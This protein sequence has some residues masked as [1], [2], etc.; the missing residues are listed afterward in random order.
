MKFRKYPGG[1]RV[2]PVRKIIFL[3]T[4][5][6]LMLAA[7]GRL[8]GGITLSEK[9]V[10]LENIFKEIHK[11]AGY[12]FI[13]TRE[14]LRLCHPVSID[15]KDADITHVLD[16]CFK[17][18]PLTYTLEEDH[19]VVKKKELSVNASAVN[20][21]PV[22]VSGRVT[23]EQGEPLEGVTVVVKS[24]HDG[25][26][27]DINGYFQLKGVDEKA[28]LVFS[29]VNVESIELPLNGR[30]ELTITLKPRVIALESISVPVNTGYQQI[31]KERAT[32]AFTNISSKS[33]N[34]QVTTNILRRLEVLA[35]GVSFGK[36]SYFDPS[37]QM[38]IRGLSTLNG[39]QNPLI[40][41]D[42]FPY[43]GD[44]NN[45][46]PNDVENITI[47]KDAA[48][49]S[50]WG[51]R[52]ANGVVVIT[53]KKAKFDQPISIDFN[54]GIKLLTK[55]DLDYLPT[56]ST[57]DFIDV[58]QFL[59][60]KQYRFSDTASTSKPPFTP[61]YEILFQQRNG[62]I[63]AQEAATRINALRNLDLRD[64]FSKYF[65]TATTSQQYALNLKGGS[66]ALSWLMSLG[67]DKDINEVNANYQR[68]TARYANSIK[69]TKKLELSTSIS[70]IQSENRSGRPHF[71]DIFSKLGG[72]PP[73]TRFADANGNALPVIKDLRQTFIDTAGGGKLQD[74]NYYPLQDYKHS[75]TGKNIYDLVGKL[76]LNYKII[77]PLSFS[78]SYQYEKQLAKQKD[79][80]DEQ[81]YSTRNLVNL[82]SQLNRSTGQVSYKIPLGSIMDLT[83]TELTANNLRG[84]FNFNQRWSEHQISAIA[85]AEARE[86]RTNQD[87]YRT[88]GYN[89]DLLTFGNVDFTTAYPMYVQQSRFSTTSFIPNRQGISE[90]L[91]RFVSFFMNASYVFRD[92]Y[93]F[94]L[95][96]RKDASNIF[97]VS[98]NKKWN[99]LWSAGLSWELSKEP[100]YRLPALPYL[101]L[102][103][104]YGY[105]GNLDPSLS[106]VTTIAYMGN[107][108]YTGFPFARVDKFYNPDL[109]W[110][111][112]AQWDLAIDLA[113]K[114]QR[115]TGSLD[116]YRKE[117][118]ELYG[119]ALVDY[120]AGLST[121]T[122][123]K[124]V[125]SM[126]AYGW[127]LQLNTLNTNS[128][129]KWS[130]QWN[131]N[132]YHDEIT[133][134]YL[135]NVRALSFMGN[136]ISKVVGSPVYS[137]FSYNWAGLDPI[138]GDPRGYLNG[139]V[140]KNY[141]ALLNDSIQNVRYNG[142][143]MPTFYG[144]LVN[145]VS[146][147]N[148]S[149]SA[150]LLFKMG[151]YFKRKTIEYDNLYQSLTGHPDYANRWQKP[152]DEL[153]TKVPSLN[154]P[155]D[156]NRDQFYANSE[157]V[158]EKG[159]NL[160]LQFVTMSY[161]LPGKIFK[162]GFKRLQVY[163]NANNLGLLW[164][165]NSEGLDPDY[166]NGTI[167]Q[168]KNFVFGLRAGF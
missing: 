27:T 89:Q 126:R 57:S 10:S 78:L 72:P 95:S 102:R 99:P 62:Q 158:V 91:N 127:E 19:V 119:P 146:F 107:S 101:R 8:Q 46:N 15:V 85:G 12:H 92:K 82:F 106:A 111:K 38:H 148:L 42:D 71:G 160:R 168:P 11:Q 132:T 141:S 50:I 140:S 14:E 143:V 22:E 123:T 139:A 49:A 150:G 44:L 16:I 65:Y 3:N 75:T 54:T 135:S 100:F 116:Y 147:K 96:G 73:Y 60:S 145:M 117:G 104:S 136:S 134:Y 6:F 98:S 157:V 66:R 142:P 109:S 69:L 64:E 25:T 120:T 61:V 76:S 45:L 24:S 18:Q 70:F 33:F 94:S 162:A 32:G 167:P 20:T 28:V 67:Y 130:T 21:L 122:I 87:F 81:S 29:G 152:G 59:F 2:F 133:S 37:G 129:V 154:Y 84:Q 113:T 77:D 52:A 114:N 30:K 58:E 90:Q 34:Q 93:T 39:P 74:W 51:A 115:I 144:S 156:P 83:N 40:V 118:K 9:N 23:N 125:A 79:L 108:P 36:K 55:P 86:V 161:D 41:V 163:V 17:D 47:L 128:A 124:N 151:H 105:N 165:A 13:F 80:N 149:L 97:G 7:F 166:L 110:E 103:S 159:D 137:V 26:S 5:L 53:T 48:A 63:S 31:P 56:M 153:N 88:F 4:L 43:E 112:N 1:L 155:S 35:N 138:N 121:G 164:A 68:I 131:L